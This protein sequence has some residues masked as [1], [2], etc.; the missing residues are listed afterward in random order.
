MLLSTASLIYA[1]V[2]VALYIVDVGRPHSPTFSSA[3]H[4]DNCRIGALLWPIGA[5]LIALSLAIRHRVPRTRMTL[6][7]RI[8]C[9]LLRGL[10]PAEKRRMDGSAY[11]CKSKLRVL[12]GE[13]MVSRVAQSGVV[14]DF[15]CGVGSDSIELANLGCQHVIGLDI[16]ERFLRSAR[17]SAEAA[18]V[19]DRCTFT[20]EA[21]PSVDAIVSIDAFEHFADPAAVLRS[22]Y[23][24]LKTGGRVY[25]SFGPTW[26][27]PLGGHLFSV[28]PW[29]HL[30][31]S[32]TALCAWR[33]HIRDD[34]AQ[35]FADVAGGLNQMTI[36]RFVSFGERE[37][38]APGVATVCSDSPSSSP[39]LGDYP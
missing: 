5:V 2:A 14:L 35:R 27:H 22:M 11:A 30:L 23:A 24:M 4:R 8:K 32:E 12:L 25:A 36:R 10:Y 13:Q 15:G 17:V 18:G 39:A 31:F 6:V 21:P 37:S 3:Q 9:H 29:A 33:S 19:A 7:D 20:T 34:G 16:Q 28:F 1:S 38:L 26:Y